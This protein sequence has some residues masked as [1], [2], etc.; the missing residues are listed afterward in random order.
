MTD[1]TDANQYIEKRRFGG[2]GQ[3]DSDEDSDDAYDPD[4]VDKTPNTKR[5]VKEEKVKKEVH[6]LSP[7]E[8]YFTLLK[9]FVCSSILYLPKS[10]VNGGWLWTSVCLFI[11]MIVTTG[12]AMLLLEIR[13]KT[14]A[15]SYQNIGLM[16]FGKPGKIAVSFALVGS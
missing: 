13:V 3:D 12:C 10:F 8:S 11:S 7:M 4:L 9:G 1:K 2:A 15:S 14:K 6:K 16:L 5:R